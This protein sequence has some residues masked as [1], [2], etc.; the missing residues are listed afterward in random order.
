MNQFD[1][2]NL[3]FILNAPIEELQLF[4]SQCDTNDLL[5]L[6]SLVNN[7][8]GTLRLTEVEQFDEVTEVK[9]AATFLKRFTLGN[10]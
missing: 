1:R 10:K 6:M 8:L 9:E 2:D 5:Y 4:Y 3:N 7:E